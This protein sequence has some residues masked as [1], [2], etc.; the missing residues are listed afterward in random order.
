MIHATFIVPVSFFFSLSL[1]PI[2]KR[3]EEE[4]TQI[5]NKKRSKELAFPFFIRHFLL[6]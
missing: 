6:F 3:Q 2:W 5:L 1:S 4:E